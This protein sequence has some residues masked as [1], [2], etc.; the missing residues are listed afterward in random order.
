MAFPSQNKMF[1]MNILNPVLLTHPRYFRGCWINSTGKASWGAP[2]I[3]PILLVPLFNFSL[4]FFLSC[5]TETGGGAPAASSSGKKGKKGKAA[6]AG[7]FKDYTVEYAKSGRA[8]CRGCGEK[9]LK[10]F[11]LLFDT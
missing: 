8:G 10:V 2:V 7:A 11:I 6:A 1:N 5:F 9:I 4:S 3:I